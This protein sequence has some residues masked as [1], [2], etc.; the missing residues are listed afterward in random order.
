MGIHIGNNNNISNSNFTNNS[1]QKQSDKSK[2]FWEKHPFLLSLI[3][4]LLVSIIMLFSF[5]GKI[6]EFIE[7]IFK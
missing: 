7:N 4:G 2:K 5:W 6:I 1:I 3:T